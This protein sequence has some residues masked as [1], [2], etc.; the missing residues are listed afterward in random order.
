[1][2]KLQLA[3]N[4]SILYRHNELKHKIKS[5]CRIDYSAIIFIQTIYTSHKLRREKEKW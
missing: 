4:R 5:F 1:M 3:K 2:Y